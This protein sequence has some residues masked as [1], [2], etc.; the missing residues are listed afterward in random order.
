PD[1]R[2]SAR[3]HDAALS[4]LPVPDPALPG[5]GLC[6]PTALPY[7]G[8][9]LAAATTVAARA[10][11][12]GWGQGG[13]PYAHAC[14]PLAMAIIRRVP[15]T[16]G[17]CVDP[18]LCRVVGHVAVPYVGSRPGAGQPDPG[19]VSLGHRQPGRPG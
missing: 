18:A 14:W 4:L 8:I 16:A 19:M 2:A 6:H 3:D 17:V 11:H 15:A 10:L 13:R 12:H 7:R 9:V 5:R 1:P